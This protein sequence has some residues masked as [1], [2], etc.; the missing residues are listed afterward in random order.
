MKIEYR[1]FN[2]VKPNKPVYCELCYS[3][4]FEPYCLVLQVCVDVKEFKPICYQCGRLIM[5]VI[6]KYNNER[7]PLAQFVLSK[8]KT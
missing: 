3:K 8:N 4:T 5:K 7:M 6:D 2:L 1:F